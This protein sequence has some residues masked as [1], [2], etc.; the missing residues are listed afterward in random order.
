MKQVCHTC[1]LRHALYTHDGT[2]VPGHLVCPKTF[3]HWRSIAVGPCP[4]WRPL[5]V[6]IAYPGVPIATMTNRSGEG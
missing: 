5:L 2:R 6:A 4:T 3:T 1:E